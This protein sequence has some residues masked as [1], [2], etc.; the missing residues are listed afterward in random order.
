MNRARAALER[1]YENALYSAELPAGRVEFRVGQVPRGAAPKEALAIIT[2]WDPGSVRRSETVNREA[3]VRLAAALQAGGWA[4]HPARACAP[5]GTHEEP[6]FAVPGM[7]PDSARALARAFGQVAVFYWDGTRAC[8][9]WCED[10]PLSASGGP[11][12]SR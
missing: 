8:L 10:Q 6:S 11:P 5:D 3:G 9:I 4:F 1:A 2:A 12:S 7:G